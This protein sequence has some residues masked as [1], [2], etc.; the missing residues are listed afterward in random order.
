[1][2]ELEAVRAELRKL[3]KQRDDLASWKESA[4]AVEREWDEQQI[5]TLLG[6]VLGES[7]RRVI[8]RRVPEILAERDQLRAERDEATATVESLSDHGSGLSRMKFIDA[9]QN[10]IAALRALLLRLRA[11]YDHPWPNEDAETTT[12]RELLLRDITTLLPTEK[13]IVE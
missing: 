3:I 12:H 13:K 1:M 2:S 11:D 6:G 7:C 10:E 5:A 4:L 9:Q 8:Q